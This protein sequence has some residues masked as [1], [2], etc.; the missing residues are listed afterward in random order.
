MPRKGLRIATCQFP[1]SG[2][3]GKNGS[4][5]RRYIRKAAVERADV[6]HFCETALSGYAAPCPEYGVEVFDV[7]SFQGYEWGALRE[8]T[9]AIMGLA[10][11][12]KVWVVLGS[13]HFLDARHKPM[14]SLYLI[15]P[16]G[17]IHN[18]Y[19]K[20]MCTRGDL[21][22][23]SPGSRFVTVTLKGIKCGLLICADLGNPN[24]FDAYQRRGVKVMFHSF[25]NAR[26]HG[27]IPNDET[28]PPVIQARARDAIDDRVS[29]TQSFSSGNIPSFQNI[30]MTAGQSTGPPSLPPTPP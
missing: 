1:V 26:F 3:I 21:E 16:S 19:D 2:D 28:V 6:V 10:K 13:T 29:S 17:K 7:A 18:R 4:Y 24:L 11:E 30:D 14:N 8:E 9:H 20:R 23:Y 27:P 22:V 25:Y 12:C 5:I 15:A